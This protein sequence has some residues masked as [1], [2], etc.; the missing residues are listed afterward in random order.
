MRVLVVDDEADVRKLLKTLLVINGYEVVEAENGLQ[1]FQVAKDR[2]CDLVITDQIM[3]LMNGL[4][5]I[6]RLAAERYP[7]RYLLMVDIHLTQV[8]TTGRGRHFGPLLTSRNTS[9]WICTVP[10]QWPLPAG[11]AGKR[12]SLDSLNGGD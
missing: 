7:A 2:Q 1:A 9:P 6:A 4:E 8:A 11:R 5:V 3:P 12:A 10:G